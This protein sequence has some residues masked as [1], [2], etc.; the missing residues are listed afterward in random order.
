M[1]TD[2][3]R[4]ASAAQ[5]RND[6]KKPPLGGFFLSRFQCAPLILMTE[7]DALCS[8]VVRRLGWLPCFS[9]SGC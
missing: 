1:R 2:S 9:G 5:R 8:A 7:R 4:A 6:C 3:A